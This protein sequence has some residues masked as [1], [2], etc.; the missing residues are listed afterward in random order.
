MAGIE[1]VIEVAR[2]C[3]QVVFVAL[4][5]GKGK[6]VETCSVTFTWVV[7]VESM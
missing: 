7:R 1:C 4:E 6:V 3:G 2:T 5:D